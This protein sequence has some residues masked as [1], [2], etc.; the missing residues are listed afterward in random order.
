MRGR[1]KRIL[2]FWLAL[3]T[4]ITSVSVYLPV[5]AASAEANICFWYAS[6]TEH[7]VVS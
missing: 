3:L 5:N 2:A 7:G 4:I 1:I 6:A